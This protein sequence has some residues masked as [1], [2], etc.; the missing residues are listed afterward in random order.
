MSEIQ[1]GQGPSADSQPSSPQPPK[2]KVNP[3]SLVLGMLI[4][5]L[6][7]F[8]FSGAPA[9]MGFEDPTLR[10]IEACPRA[11]EILGTPVT[12]SWWGLSC[13][14][15]ETGDGN[16][17]AS[18]RFPVAG[19]RGSGSIEVDAIERN[20]TWTVQQAMLETSEATLDV[21]SCTE[22]GP[23]AI[24]AQTVRASV[25]SIIGSPGVAQG[26]ACTIAI[27]EGGGPFNCRVQITCGATTL[28]GAGSTGYT[29]CT[30]DAQGATVARDTD[31]TPSGGDPTLDLRLGA[32]EAVLTDQTPAGTWVVSMRIDR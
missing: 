24:T 5:P 23:I 25:T 4:W 16:G 18:W 14:N 6:G 7:I 13:G 29:R 30:R 27:G 3:L 32:G 19:S 9:C 15:A 22:G 10:A 1:F 12:R 26:D 17:N 11:V 20:G 31:P 28:Y 21:L 2:K 8:A